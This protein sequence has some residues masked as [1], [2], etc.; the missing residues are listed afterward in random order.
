[1]VVWH[2]E[3]FEF[4]INLHGCQLVGQFFAWKKFA[5]VWLQIIAIC[6]WVVVLHHLLVEKDR[7][8]IFV[9]PSVQQLA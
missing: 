8:R 1:L 5:P 3:D 9:F 2:L 7:L 6:Q 4:V